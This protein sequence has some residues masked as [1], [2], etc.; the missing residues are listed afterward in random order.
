VIF[1][2][3]GTPTS[4]FGGGGGTKLFCSQALSATNADMAKTILET[5]AALCLTALFSPVHA[6]E[7]A[8]FIPCLIQS[9]CSASFLFEDF[10]RCSN[11]NNLLAV[12]LEKENDAT[13]FFE[14]AF[15][16]ASFPLTR[17]RRRQQ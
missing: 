3:T 9:C 15:F 13:E 7:R 1:R 2:C 11:S 16:R 8:G 14:S 10:P 5:A 12:E 17:R 6:G 4:T